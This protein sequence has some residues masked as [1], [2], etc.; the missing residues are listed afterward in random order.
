MLSLFVFCSQA[1]NGDGGITAGVCFSLFT[2]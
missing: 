2:I 1:R